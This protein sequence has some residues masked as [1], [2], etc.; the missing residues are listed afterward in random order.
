MSTNINN[1]TQFEAAPIAVKELQKAWYRLSEEEAIN[2]LYY[3]VLFVCPRIESEKLKHLQ[4]Y[5]VKMFIHFIKSKSDKCFP[6]KPFEELSSSEILSVA[7]IQRSNN[8][9]T[10]LWKSFVS[11]FQLLETALNM[12]G[13]TIKFPKNFQ[14]IVVLADDAAVLL[15]KA[16]AGEECVP[17]G[18][19]T[20]ATMMSNLISSFQ[21]FVIEGQTIPTQLLLEILVS[22]MMWHTNLRNPSDEA[23]YLTI[24]E[25]QQLINSYKSAPIFIPSR[26][27]EDMDEFV[28]MNYCS[29]SDYVNMWT[30][31]TNVASELTH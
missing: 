14:G 7:E 26:Y 2:I 30:G 18:N 16:G 15:P 17:V 3:L 29:T 24:R 12:K 28:R 6:T 20:L 13:I 23:G 10:H 25:V 11:F 21:D 9:A 8:Y 4:Y 5:L 22:A 19:I 31:A 1:N 27:N